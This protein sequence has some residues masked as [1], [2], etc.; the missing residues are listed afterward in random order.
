MECPRN[1]DCDGGCGIVG[2]A[3]GIA[4]EMCE[5]ICQLLV[6][7]EKKISH[8]QSGYGLI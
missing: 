8:L 3:L 6:V 1:V 7:A 2:D 4:C 5:N